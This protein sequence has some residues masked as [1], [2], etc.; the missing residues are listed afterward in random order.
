MLRKSLS[1]PP[2]SPRSPIQKGRVLFNLPVSSLPQNAR[3]ERATLTASLS[4]SAEEKTLILQIHPI[5]TAWNP[6][7]VDWDSGWNTPGG[8]VDLE[9][10]AREEV[11]LSDGAASLAIDLTHLMK[12]ILEEGLTAHGLLVTVPPYM[13]EGFE[14]GDLQRLSNISSAS[15]DLVQRTYS[16]PPPWASDVVQSE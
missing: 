4:G 5:T 6:A 1:F 15:L 3:I 8:D 16:A 9:L 13:G 11:D 10:Y 2:T 14:A 12:E 7:D